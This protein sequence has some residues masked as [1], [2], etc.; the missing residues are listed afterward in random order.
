M[1]ARQPRP[2]RTD[3]RHAP[4]TR[5]AAIRQAAF[6]VTPPSPSRRHHHHAAI[7]ITL[8]SRHAAITVT[9]LPCG[10]RSAGAGRLAGRP[11][12]RG[13]LCSPMASGSR[14]VTDQSWRSN[15]W[16]MHRLDLDAGEVHADALVRAAAEGL[17]GE[18]VHLV[19]RALRT[20]PLRVER[21][22][23]RPVLAHVVGEVRR[24]DT[25]VSAG[26]KWPSISVSLTVRRAM[27]GTGATSRRLSFITRSNDRSSADCR[28]PATA[29]PA[30]STPRGSGPAIPGAGPTGRASS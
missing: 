24:D 5:H 23:V 7:T 26:M 4:M 3:D 13:V 17:P 18:P 9:P 29:C 22:R 21:L 28:V 2:S 25:I 16:C 14:W 27:L 1:T 12:D 19:L 15:N 6:T 11:W 8:H 10:W 20:E 30:R